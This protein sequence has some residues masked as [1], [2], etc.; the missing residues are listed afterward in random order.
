MH[1]SGHAC[2]HEAMTNGALGLDGLLDWNQARYVARTAGK[3]LAA[4]SARLDEAA[5]A[6]LARAI[7]TLEDDP[8]CDVAAID[9]Y[10]VCGEGPWRIE[11]LPS[12]VALSP[13]CASR[14]RAGM[15]IPLH[16]DSVLH[17]LKTEITRADI[18]GS[19]PE[20]ITA[21]DELTGMPDEHA[22]PAFGHGILRQGEHSHAGT[23]LIAANKRVTPA[24][25]ALAA[26]TGHDSLEVL[27]PPRVGTLVLGDELLD[28]GLPRYGRPRDALGHMIPAFIGEIGGRGFPPTR[29]PDSPGLLLEEINDAN[30]DVLI[31]TGSTAPGP[32]SH[33]RQ[34]LRDLDA[35]WMVDGV[36]VSPGAPMLMAR[37]PDGRI[38]IGLPGDPI[39]ALCALMTLATPLILAMRD[40]PTPPARM[41]TI[42]DDAPAPEFAEDTSMHPVRLDDGT[43][44]LLAPDLHG[45]AL[46]DA[47]VVAP[48]GT[49]V[50]GDTLLVLDHLG[51]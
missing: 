21:R 40:D 46:A 50:R 49:G 48:P 4:R 19:N 26:A 39:G 18:S 27:P 41:A 22:R 16:T 12:G 5:G 24:V 8:S 37:L 14:V 43:A 45:W 10:A 9:G 13:H 3:A 34:V 2:Q 1:E 33:L 11:E 42:T 29:A 6:N 44:N 30:V 32:N 47:Y 28:R 7:L 38:L 20:I 31:T 36:M 35:H 15:P 51:R 17:H 23:S 25:L